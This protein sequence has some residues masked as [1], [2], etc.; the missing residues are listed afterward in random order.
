VSDRERRPS[1]A[2][3]LAPSLVGLAEPDAVRRVQ[4]AGLHPQVVPAEA[5]AI[6]MDFRERR[7]RLFL[8]DA[9]QVVRATAG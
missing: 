7:I 1:E 2:E 9:G 3:L 8:D 6:T 4:E 5:D